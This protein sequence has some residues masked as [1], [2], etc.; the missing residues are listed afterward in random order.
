LEYDEN[1]LDAPA[2]KDRRICSWRRSNC[3][4]DTPSVASISRVGVSGAALSAAAAV[5]GRA[6]AGGDVDG[7]V[8]GYKREKRGFLPPACCHVSRILPFH[9][10]THVVHQ[11][12]LQSFVVG[13][14]PSTATSR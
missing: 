7:V 8:T 3:W 11:T 12:T 14:S 6:M 1:W 2:E 10:I 9:P 4:G 5:E 13:S